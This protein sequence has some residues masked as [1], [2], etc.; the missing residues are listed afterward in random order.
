MAIKICD[1]FC[2]ESHEYECKPHKHSNIHIL[3]S[4]ISTRLSSHPRHRQNTV[5]RVP[6]AATVFH[7]LQRHVGVNSYWTSTFPASFLKLAAFSCTYV[8]RHGRLESVRVLAAL[9]T[10][11][12]AKVPYDVVKHERSYKKN[13][14]LLRT[15]SAVFPTGAD[16]KVYCKG[17]RAMTM[18]CEFIKV[19]QPSKGTL[20][21]YRKYTLAI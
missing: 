13:L 4:H 5:Y 2:G 1:K 3:C 15:H 12:V 16:L 11:R 19:L 20:M 18:Y 14:E 9:T 21:I 6:L 10:F 7:S 17:T 8:Y